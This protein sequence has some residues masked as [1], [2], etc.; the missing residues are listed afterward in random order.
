MTLIMI[1]VVVGDEIEDRDED[2]INFEIAI[3]N[4]DEGK[5]CLGSWF[6]RLQSTFFVEY[7]T[8]H[9]MVGVY[10]NK[11][12][13]QMEAEKHRRKNGPNP[14]MFI[15]DIPAMCSLQSPHPH[16]HSTLH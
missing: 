5:I 1:V 10:Q 3:S 8:E 11:Y 2:D 13:H 12:D 4:L 16:I 9:S 15:K 7:D 14:Q 6:L